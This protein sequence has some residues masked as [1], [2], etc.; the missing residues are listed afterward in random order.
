MEAVCRR[1]RSSEAHV[2][3]PRA[4]KA[5][6]NLR[7]SQADEQ[8]GAQQK[9]RPTST[10]RARHRELHLQLRPKETRARSR[11]TRSH[12][13]RASSRP[14]EAKWRRERGSRQGRQ[15]RKGRGKGNRALQAQQ[16]ARLSPLTWPHGYGS[17]GQRQTKEEST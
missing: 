12:G 17:H 9:R 15:R 7:N 8:K 16:E 14:G 13:E 10:K 11:T 3:P 4:R 1:R 2:D 6:T 5:A